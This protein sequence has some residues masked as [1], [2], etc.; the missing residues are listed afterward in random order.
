MTCSSQWGTGSRSRLLAVCLCFSLII[1]LRQASVPANSPGPILRIEE[2]WSLEISEPSTDDTSPQIINTISPTTNLNGQFAI[3][4][5]NHATQPAYDDGGLELQIRNGSSLVDYKR[6]SDLS[7]LNNAGEIVTY[8]LAM[9][10]Q[11]S[12]SDGNGRQ[13]RFSVKNGV[14]ETWGTFGANSSLR[15]TTPYT[16]LLDFGGYSPDFS[17]NNSK[18]GYASFRVQKYAMVAVRYYDANGLVSTDSTERVAFKY[19]PKAVISE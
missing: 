9:S 17:V 10:I 12:Q 13:L 3:F 8:T 19:D 14:S 7:R 11:N 18:I 4:E 6:S 1:F 5:I 2:D 15:C 16:N